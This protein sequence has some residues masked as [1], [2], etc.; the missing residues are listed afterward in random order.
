MPTKKALLLIVIASAA[1]FFACDS[2]SS[3]ST[4][5]EEIGSSNSQQVPAS[6][7]ES[8][9]SIVDSSSTSMKFN[10]LN[11]LLTDKQAEAVEIIKSFANTNDEFKDLADSCEDGAKSSKEVQGQIVEFTCSCGTWVPTSGLDEL[12]ES[13][14]PATQGMLL[15]FTGMTEEEIRELL[16]I[17][18]SLG[19]QESVNN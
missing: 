18:S 12:F 15:A 4:E 10:T 13:M 3:V 11:G 9:S 6:N 8:S 7:E 2:S 19:K 5:Q 1:A 14:D 17:L 16:N